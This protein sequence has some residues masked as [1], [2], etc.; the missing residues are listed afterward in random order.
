MASRDLSP[1]TGAAT[2]S[3][4]PPMVNCD[5]CDGPFILPAEIAAQGVIHGLLV[6]TQCVEDSLSARQLENQP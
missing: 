6:C 2:P 1:N 5:L 4:L 3:A